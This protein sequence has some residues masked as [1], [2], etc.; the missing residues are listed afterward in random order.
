M[1]RNPNCI[2]CQAISTKTG[3]RCSRRTCQLFPYCWQHLRLIDG[4][5]VKKS[6]IPGVGLGLYSFNKTFH[7]GDRIV[8]Y[9]GDVKPFNPHDPK[10]NPYG[11][12]INKKEIIDADNPHRHSVARYSN[13]CRPINKQKHQC[14]GNNAKLVYYDPKDVKNTEFEPYAGKVFIEAIK[15][16]HPGE[17][18]FVSYGKAYW[19]DMKKFGKHPANLHLKI[20][21]SFW[22]E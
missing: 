3:R 20:P 18:I 14:A 12:Q 6:Q 22:N 5:A 7:K 17:E 1:P 21:N 8:E 10:L 11:V 9:T 2:T 16:I 4:L 19:E 15:T 13:D